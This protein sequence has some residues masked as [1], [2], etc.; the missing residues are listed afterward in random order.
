MPNIGINVIEGV[1]SGAYPFQGVSLYNVAMLMERERGIPNF[2]VEITS[3][4]QDRLRFNG[5]FSGKLASHMVRNMFKNARDFGFRL[6]GVRVLGSSSVAAST[7][8]DLFRRDDPVQNPN[9]WSS[10]PMIKFWAGQKGMKDPGTW[11]NYSQ[12]LKTGVKFT[13][14]EKDSLVKGSFA[15]RIYYKEDLK[16]TW[17][18]PSLRELITVV[19][20]NSD[21]LFAEQLSEFPA[22]PEQARINPFYP[23]TSEPNI[24]EDFLT[25]G[26][27]T[28]PSLSDYQVGGTINNPT[29]LKV[30]DNL[31]IQIFT[32]DN[33]V[34]AHTTACIDYANNHI[35]KPIFV[36]CLPYNSSDTAVRT[37]MDAKIKATAE[38]AAI[39]N[40]WVK[41]S[42]DFGSTIYV[43]ASGAIIGAGFIRVA[44]QNRNL[45]HFPPAGLEA[46][47]DDVIDAVPNSIPMDVRTEWAK[48]YGTNFLEFRKNIGWFPFSSRTTSSNSL[49]QSIHIR[50]MT[51]K[52]RAVLEENMLRFLQ[53]PLTREIN[54]EMYVSLLNYFQTEWADGGLNNNIT[55]DKACVI[56]IEGD[57]S[58]PKQVNITVDLIYS[59]CSETI[60]IT[61]NRNDFSLLN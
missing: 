47:L 51:S 24:I 37:I 10:Y 3:L 59:E 11:A 48:R 40:A 7:T 39:Y 44:A 23:F 25:T 19:N 58:D 15:I 29:G 52:Y 13:L 43:P 55:F 60:T 54:R 5:A 6:Y 22:L 61:L 14:H 18:A 56:N 12:A 35:K 26:T 50:R 41:T 42:D 16:E 1:S 45:I 20:L 2:P 30:L 4:A 8:V 36:S 53:K 28:S 32:T 34:D 49:Y 27:Y 57:K 38:C 31:D 33:T 46:V 21:Y 17:T 9:S